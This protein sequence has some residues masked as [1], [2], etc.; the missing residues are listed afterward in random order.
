M[1]FR[2]TFMDGDYR[3]DPKTDW[4]CACCQK[5]LKPAASYRVVHLVDDGPYVLHPDDEAAYQ[6]QAKRQQGGQNTGDLGCFPV[7]MDCARRIGMEWTH[8][9]TFLPAPKTVTV[10]KQ[11]P[12]SPEDIL[13]AM[14]V[15]FGSGSGPKP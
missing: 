9:A 10:S 11:E 13:K 3:R 5:D 7:G 14:G 8:E 4:Y 1:K 2:T 15:R 12:A 6:E